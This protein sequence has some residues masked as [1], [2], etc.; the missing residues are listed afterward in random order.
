MLVYSL[1]HWLQT[2]ISFYTWILIARILLSWVP[3]NW[4]QQPFRFLEQLTEPVL[5]PFRQLIPPL[6]GVLDISPIVVFLLLSVL[7]GLLAN[8]KMQL[9]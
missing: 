3:V 5:A 6:G 2:A 9:L 7:E 4:S 1:L 8:L